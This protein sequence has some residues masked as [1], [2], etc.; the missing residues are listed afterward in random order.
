MSFLKQ[1]LY[2]VRVWM[3]G[4][5]GVDQL[6]LVMLLGSLLLQ[7][8]AALTGFAPLLFL[9]IGLYGWVLFRIF[10]KKS[11][12][13]QQENTKF[14]AWWT[15]VLTRTRQFLLRLKLRKQY[16]YFKCPQC[17]TLL[18]AARGRGEKEMC[19]PKCRN[20][21]MIQTG[22][23]KPLTGA[24]TPNASDQNAAGG[25]KAADDPFAK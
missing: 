4:R 21:F 6:S 10:S 13:R 20:R 22:R 8:L 12:A 3:Y 23:A 1:L 15:M 5:N 18:R 25:Q 24:S 14:L 2:K 16:K 11:F 19:C 9:S 7:L 17:K